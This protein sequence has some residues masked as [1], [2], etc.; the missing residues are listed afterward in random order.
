MDLVNQ[1]LRQLVGGIAAR[2]AATE[3]SP[4]AERVGIL[5]GLMGS[6]S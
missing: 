4:H 3:K 1:T 2:R 5:S 6:R